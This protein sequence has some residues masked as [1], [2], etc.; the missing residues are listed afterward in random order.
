M[1]SSI[2]S[3]IPPELDQI[4]VKALEKDADLSYQTASDLRADLKRIKREIDSSPSWN[5]VSEPQIQTKTVA[6]RN[7]LFIALTIIFISLMAF[8]GWFLFKNRKMAEGI[9]WSKGTNTQL[10]EQSGIEYFPSIAPDGKSFVFASDAKGN[11]DIYSQRIGGKNPTNLTENSISDDTQ[12]AFS[13]DGNRIAFRSERSPAGIYVMEATGENLRRVGDG[14]HP[15]WSPDGKEIVVSTNGMDAPNVLIGKDNG[16][17][18]INLETGAKRE[19]LKQN[20]YFPTWS[21]NKKRIAYWFYPTAI[22]RRDI[23]TISADGK[24]EPIVLTGEFALS[25]WNPVWSPDG[26]FLYFVSDKNGNWNFWR[27]AI[28]ENSGKPLGEPE[29]IVTPSKYSRHLAFSADGKKMIY[30]QSETES[31]IQ[32]VDFDDKNEKIIGNPSWVTTGDRE[33]TR[34]ILSPDGKQFL[35]RQIRRTQDDIVVVNQDGTGWHDITNDTPFDRFPRWSPDGSQIALASD[36]SGNYEIWMCNTDGTNLRQITFPVSVSIATSFPVFSPDGKHLAFNRPPNSYILDLTKDYK[37]QTPF[38]LPATDTGN[39][40]GVWDWS[41]DGKK[42]LGIFQNELMIGYFSFESNTY[43]RILKAPGSVPS[44]LPDS[45]HFVY[46][47]NNKVFLADIE[48]KQTKEL[49]SLQIEQPRSPFVTPDGKNLY[50]VAHLNKS[51]IWLIDAPS[52]P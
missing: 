28:D 35:M 9:D 12:P 52:A 41:P 16:L 23:A 34:A 18:I 51:D 25:N 45:R 42:L 6:T 47:E 44:W 20:A 33:V 31:N 27:V 26:K 17:S 37:S 46:A 7:Y 49:L 14:A 40:F 2:N 22:G 15:S 38:K 3:E 11:F 39:L 29:P 36:R 10:T 50:Y 5:S 24:A 43:T 48:T 1:A 8:G 32:R 4:L 19:L 21:P 30:V 13:P